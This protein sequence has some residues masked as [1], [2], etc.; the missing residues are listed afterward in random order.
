MLLPEEVKWLNDYHRH[1]YE[2]L[3][4]HLDGEDKAWL[5]QATTAI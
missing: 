1:V 2:T 5:E 4:P 3:A